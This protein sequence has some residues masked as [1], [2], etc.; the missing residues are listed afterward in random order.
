MRVTMRKLLLPA[1]LLV[2]ATGCGREPG[3]QPDE[4]LD[5]S[6]DNF[7]VNFD[8]CTDNPSWRQLFVDP[9]QLSEARRAVK[10][11]SDALTADMLDCAGL[12]TSA[13]KPVEPRVIFTVDGLHLRY[14]KTTL[15]DVENSTCKISFG[16]DIV[17]EDRG[18]AM[19]ETFVYSYALEGE[20]GAC[21]ELDAQLAARG[22]NG[23]GI[24]GCTVTVVSEGSL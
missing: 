21:A 18:N 13:C 5:W 15:S 2:T 12:A 9:I 6:I 24:D 1:L 19:T 10:V 11:S 23:I 4:V 22:T 8:A 7:T 17:I 16:Q 14:A 20:A 3:F